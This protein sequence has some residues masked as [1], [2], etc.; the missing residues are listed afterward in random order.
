MRLLIPQLSVLLM[1]LRLLGTAEDSVAQINKPVNGTATF[2]Y[3]FKLGA[4][5]K[6]T[7]WK[8]SQG[9]KREVAEYRNQY[10]NV[11]DDELKARAVFNQT[12]LMIQNLAMT[13]SGAYY[14][15]CW[16]APN[17]ISVFNLTVYKPVQQPVIK[18][19]CQCGCNDCN[20]TLYC[21]DPTNSSSAHWVILHNS[22]PVNNS[23]E[24]T[25]WIPL[26]NTSKST[27][28]MCVLQNPADQ[29][30]ASIGFEQL[31]FTSRYS[32]F[33]CWVW[34]YWKTCI[35]VTM[36][37]LVILPIIVLAKKI[38]EAVLRKLRGY[39]PSWRTEVDNQNKEGRLGDMEMTSV[40]SKLKDNKA[41]LRKLRGYFPSWRTE[42]DNQNKECRM[43]D[44]E[45]ASVKSQLL[46]N[47][48]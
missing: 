39:F 24:S 30:N 38:K 48:G 35:Y 19:E 36:A 17:R 9:V 10:F 11:S 20:C 7:I 33:L 22:M 32:K 42:V 1:S 27:K 29:R 15:K 8:T 4:K 21:Q 45:M 6:C 40:K 23:S 2:H 3:G 37:V 47:T 14:L 44:M 12:E 31:C 25:I 34:S 5:T 28:Y 16:L 46:D 18:T 13:D 26:G 41:V 43:G